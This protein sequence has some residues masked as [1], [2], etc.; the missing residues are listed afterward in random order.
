MNIIQ[1][2]QKSISQKLS[3]NTVD[4]EEKEDIFQNLPIKNENELE[5]IETKLNNDST[6]KK[7]M[8]I[9]LLFLYKLIL[10]IE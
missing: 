9:I 1:G 7:H 4:S 2:H 6:Y 8:V 3:V 10:N 5:V